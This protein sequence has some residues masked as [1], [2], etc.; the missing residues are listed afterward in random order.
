MT[1]WELLISRHNDG[2]VDDDVYVGWSDYYGSLIARDMD[3]EWW[4]AVKVEYDDA[5][6]D[7]VDA[8]YAE[9]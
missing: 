4:D 5:L 8:A 2:L 9:K 7:A 1:H 6:V 3:S